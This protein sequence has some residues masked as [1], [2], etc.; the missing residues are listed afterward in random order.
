MYLR[1][2]IKKKE[3]GFVPFLGKN[4]TRREIT[5]VF[6]YGYGNYGF[7][8]VI[9]IPLGNDQMKSSYQGKT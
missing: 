3:T 5:R 1:F 8:K 6:L 7:H 4:M 2:K 9:N